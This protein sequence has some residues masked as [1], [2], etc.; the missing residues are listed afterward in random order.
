MLETFLEKVRRLEQ[1]SYLAQID[2]SEGISVRI[3]WTSDDSREL[4]ENFP[5]DESLLALAATFRLFFQNREVVGLNKMR[6]LI[7][8]PGI[9]DEWKDAFR[10]TESM[11]NELL[12]R[13]STLTVNGLRLK[14]RDVLDTVMYGDLV[15]TDKRKEFRNVQSN[16][17]F[18]LNV[19]FNFHCIVVNMC[20]IIMSLG[21]HS[22]IELERAK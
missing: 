4:E 5:S 3:S 16:P 8:D 7:S 21:F 19:M 12:N 6:R 2:K 22:E 20:Q 9:S 11:W 17:E 15:H 10:L 18:H 14:N 1:S 13:G